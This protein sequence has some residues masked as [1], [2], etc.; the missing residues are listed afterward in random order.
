MPQYEFTCHDGRNGFSKVLFQDDYEQ[1]TPNPPLLWKRQGG[2]NASCRDPVD[3]FFRAVPYAPRKPAGVRG[4]FPSLSESSGPQSNW[5][6][7][8]RKYVLVPGCFSS[9]S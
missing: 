7:L 8:Q 1:G 4:A 5:R 9:C 6:V 3:P 2:G